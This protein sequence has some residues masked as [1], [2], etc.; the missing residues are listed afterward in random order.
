MIECRFRGLANHPRGDALGQK[1]R[2][3]KI[4]RDQLV[5]ALFAG[6]EDIGANARRD[7]GVVDQNIQPAELG[8]DRL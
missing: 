1:I 8:F 5:E 4:G 3:A 7:A 2:P 6:L